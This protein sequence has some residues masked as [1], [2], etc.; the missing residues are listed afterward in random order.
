M[1][2]IQY[3]ILDIE[4]QLFNRNI[5]QLH[6]E[7]DAVEYG[8]QEC[9]LIKEKNPYYIQL[10]LNSKDLAGIHAYESMGFRF[11]EFRIFRYLQVIEHSVSNSYSFPFGCELVGNSTANKKVL[12]E[13]AS[14]HSSDDRFTCDPLISDELAKKR[15]ELYIS[16]S[17]AEF[18]RQFVY[19]LFNKQSRELLGF[20]TGIFSDTRIVKYFYYFMKKDYNLP[21]YI[22]MLESG[23]LSA[24]AEKNVN[25]I[26][27]VS[28]GSNV[29]E[30]NDSSITQ[31]FI[32]DKTMILLRKLL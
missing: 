8:L 21:N 31:R 3:H 28:S 2:T 29:Q 26:E 5:I 11:V 13:I 6:T 32:V 18:P 16:K 10:Q 9:T 1:N 25:I 7:T 30:M 12:L 14:Q 24:L 4:S 22:A 19:G 20:R 15:L 27:A 17:L 23:V